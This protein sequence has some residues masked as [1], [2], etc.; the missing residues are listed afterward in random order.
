MGYVLTISSK[1]NTVNEGI[2]K[3]HCYVICDYKV[4]KG[5]LWLQLRNPT[6]YT[7]I[8]PIV[9]EVTD[10]KLE[11][12]QPNGLQWLPYNYLVNNFEVISSCLIRPKY[13]YTYKTISSA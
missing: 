10:F 2:H 9:K 6:G 12:L 1:I 8:N 4:H 13:H 5:V 3:R 7:P 11:L